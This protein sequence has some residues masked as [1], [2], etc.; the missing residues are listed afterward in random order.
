VATAGD[1]PRILVVDD[2]VDNCQMLLRL[3]THAGY[4]AEC[5]YSGEDALSRL[6]RDHDGKLPDL[7]ILDQMMP[8]LDG[9]EVLR[10]LRADRRTAKLPVVI[11]SALVDRAFE[12]YALSK[13]ATAYWTKAGIDYSHLTE[14][15]DRVMNESAS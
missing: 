7:V 4:A 12:D 1:R 8:G 3:L 13:G 14:M 11:F 15:V 6:S 10:R 2:A 9:M 5:A